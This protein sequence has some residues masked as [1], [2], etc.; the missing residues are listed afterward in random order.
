[1]ISSFGHLEVSFL[2]FYGL[3]F[4]YIILWFEAYDQK[5]ILS[6]LC[7][8]KNLILYSLSLQKPLKVV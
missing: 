3:F 7:I 2:S 1:M 5:L 6:H 4:Q 8:Y